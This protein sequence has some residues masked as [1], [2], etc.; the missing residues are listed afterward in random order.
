MILPVYENTVCLFLS[1]S[2]EKDGS[3]LSDEKQTIQT[4]LFALLKDFLKSPTPEELHS[5]LAYLLTV[6]EEQQAC[7]NYTSVGRYILLLFDLFSVMLHFQSPSELSLII[8]TSFF[9][10]HVLASPYFQTR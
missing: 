3:I 4:V 10:S 5:V 2:V 8:H 9:Y 6:G 1:Y 7:F